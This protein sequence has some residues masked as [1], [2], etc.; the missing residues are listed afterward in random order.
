MV[1]IVK[2]AS[3]CDWVIPMDLPNYFVIAAIVKSVSQSDWLSDS[4]KSPLL[5]CNVRHRE[6][7]IAIWLSDSNK[8]PFPY[9]FVMS[10]IV[11]SASQFVLTNGFFP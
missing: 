11:K 3:Q 9:Y 4:N 8:S 7:S 10:G 2:S 5:F 1:A 6:I